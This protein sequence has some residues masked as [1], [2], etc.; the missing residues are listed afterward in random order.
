MAINGAAN[1]GLLAIQIL[2]TADEHLGDKMKAYKLKLK[3]T[4]EDKA[5]KLEQDGWKKY[6]SQ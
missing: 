4:V 5:S 2:A 1:A 6:L 3:S